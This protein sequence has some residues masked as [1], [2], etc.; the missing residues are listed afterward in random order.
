MG[1]IPV[2]DDPQPI[3]TPGFLTVTPQPEQVGC[4]PAECL[5]RVGA[6][7][8]LPI[9]SAAQSAGLPFGH[10][11]N[12]EVETTPLPIGSA[13]FWQMVRVRETG[14]Q[15]TWD[16][17]E[18]AL[19]ANPGSVWIVGNEPDIV[20]QDNTTAERYAELYHDV[21]SFI[22]ERDSSAQIAVAGVGQP[23]PLRL[24]YLDTVLESYE[25]RYGEPM[26]VDVW[27]IHN[28]ILR[29]ERD[30]WG[31]GIPPGMDVDQGWLYEIADHDDLEIFKSNL[32][33][34]RVWMNERGYR[35]RPLALT[36]FGILMPAD[37]GFPPHVVAEFMRETF[38]FLVTAADETIGYPADNNRLVQWWFWYSVYDGQE[39]PTGNLYDPDTDTLT[40]LGQ[41]FADYVNGE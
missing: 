34:F 24:L 9:I 1:D 29:E 16:E 39:F 3:G 5:A 8:K 33:A 18:Q 10:Y 31:V 26:P 21:Y 7:G 12:W 41:V 25:Q 11:F 19:A 17:I 30:S 38:D 23:T 37:F 13:A 2:V 6:T 14:V 22:K 15:D 40:D 36:E 32:I 4:S 28:F 27:T 35:D 20:W